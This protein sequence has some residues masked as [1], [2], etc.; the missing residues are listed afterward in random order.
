MLNRQAM[1]MM[2]D[3]KKFPTLTPPK[4]KGCRY[5]GRMVIH[6]SDIY[7][8]Y[9][10]NGNQP[11]VNEDAGARQNAF[12]LSF[13]KGIDFN[14]L[15]PIVQKRKDGKFN[16]IAGYG[17]DSGLQKLDGYEG[18]YVYD[19]FELDTPKAVASLRLWSNH[20][21]PEE[22][23]SD[24]DIVKTSVDLIN[25]K[26]LKKDESEIRKFI[27]TGEPY[28]H[29]G[30]I[31]KLVNMVMAFVG[32]SSKQIIVKITSFT[33][34]TIYSRFVRQYWA[35]IPTYGFEDCSTTN[36][37]NIVAGVWQTT[38]SS[39]VRGNNSY[40]VMLFDALARYDRD[41]IK[42]EFLLNIDKASNLKQLQDRRKYL[43][44]NI[45][46][47]R[48]TVNREDIWSKAIMFHGFVPQHEDE[49]KKHLITLDSL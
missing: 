27:R 20:W 28:L 47:F 38:M 33:H 26:G 37:P 4:I 17:R 46:H 13:Q 7:D 5:L 49:P 30:E 1:V 9:L 31:T 10:D 11:R 23:N 16:R 12:H 35:D 6:E 21:T 2:N 48:K 8:G 41:G 24:N 18:W 19:V 42:T 39:S 40:K 14:K 36:K 15:P 32:G 43:I 34:K 44:Q 29:K 22:S 45:D 25:A 3:Q